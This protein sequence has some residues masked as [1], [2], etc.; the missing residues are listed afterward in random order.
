MEQLTFK[1]ITDPKA[2]GKAFTVYPADWKEVLLPTWPEYVE[3]ARVYGL[4]QEDRLTTVGI[5]FHGAA[6]EMEAFETTAHR[7]FGEGH[8]YLGFLYTLPEYRGRG[9][10]P[11]WL[12]ALRKTLPEKMIWLTVEDP[13]LITF[14][15]TNGFILLAKSTTHEEWLLQWPT[16]KPPHH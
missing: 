11:K 15:E 2:I 1:E 13:G 14:Y 10:A 6:P 9:Y 3:T 4:F 7:L 8:P 16:G 12:K 5:L